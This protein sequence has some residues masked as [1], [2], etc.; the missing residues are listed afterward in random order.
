M[1]DFYV[2]PQVSRL[3]KNIMKTVFFISLFLLVR[4]PN[5]FAVTSSWDFSVTGNYSLSD[6]ASIEVANSSARLKVQNYVN[7]ANTSMLLHMDESSGNPADSSSNS[8]SATANSI[9]YSTGKL[10]NGAVFDGTLSYVSVADSSSLSVV[11]SNTIEGWVKHGSS[12]SA[13]S[14]QNPVTIADKGVYKL[15]YDNDTGKITYEL[16]PSNADNWTQA[17]GGNATTQDDVN[18]SWDLNGKLAVEASVAIG[19]DIYA[20]LGNAASDAEVWKWDG[21][22]WLQIGG[23]GFNSSWAAN[24][25]EEVYSIATDGTN[26]YAGL[27]STAGDGDVWKWNGANW[28]QIGGDGLNSGWAAATYEYVHALYWDGTYLYAGI[29]NSANDAEVWRWNGTAWTKIGGDSTNSGWTTNFESVLSLTG[30]GSTIYAGLGSSAGDAEVWRWNGSAWSRIGGDAINSSWADA[31]YEGVY[32]LYYQGSTLYAGIGNSAA[33]EGEVWRYNGTS[34]TKVGGDAANSSWADTTYEQVWAL[35]GDGTNIY[36]GI[37]NTAGDNEVWKYNGTSWSQIGGDGLNSGFSNT[38]I[39]VRSL[40]YVST[41]TLLY[42]GL[43]ATAA[44]GEMWSYNGTSWTRIAGNHINKSWGFYGLNSVE[45]LT[46]ANGKLYAGN[47]NATAGNALVWEFDGTSWGIVAG[48]GVNSSWAIN[49]YESVP[50]LMRYGGNLYAGL[51]TTANDGEVWKYASGSWS[52]IGGDSLN[53]SWGAGYEVVQSMT[54]FNGLLVAG[55][56]NSANDAE[57]WTYNGSTWTKIGGDSTNSGWT[58]NIE[59]VRSLMTYNGNLYAG[60][61]DSA[62]DADVWKWNGTA[63]SQIGG[64]TLNSSWASATF[65]TVDS[66]AVYNGYLVAG[67]GNSAGDAEVWQYNGS[68]WTRIGGDATNSSWA[69]ATYERVR[70]LSVFNG[71]LY[72]GLGSTAGDGEV[73]KWNGTAWSQVGGDSLNNGW[74]SAHEHVTS[75]AAYSG[76]MYAGLG[77]TANTD[78]MVYAYGGNS[79]LQS[80]SASQDTNW[81]HIAATYNGSTMKIYIDGTLDNSVAAS[82]TMLDTGTP[83]LI[84]NGFGSASPGIGSTP[85]KGML[86]EIRISNTDRS[87]FTTTAYV[88]SAQTV[89]PTASVM[90]TQVKNWD[91]FSTSETLNGGSIGYR[92]SIDNGTTWKYWNGSQWTTS[93]T[94]SQTN[95]A[96]VINTNIS[97]L[98]AGSGGILWQAVLTGDGTQ[99]V[100]L[101]TVQIGATADTTDPV[102]PDTVSALSALG[103]SPITSG[104][105]HSNT[106]PYFTWSG[107][108]DTGGSGIAGYYVYFDGTSDA[109]PVTNGSF[110]TTAV[111]TGSG[112]SSGKTYYLRIKAKDNAGNIADNAWDA[113]TYKYDGSNPTNPTT[114]SV[115]PAGYAATNSFTF[116]WPAGSDSGSNI[117]GYQYKTGASSGSLSDWST[118]TT[119]RSVEIPDAAYQE[120]ENTFYLRTVD[121][122]GN[123]SSTNVTANYYYAGAGPTAPQY[124]TVNQSTNTTNSFAFSWSP[125]SSFSGDESDLTYCYTVNTFPSESAC[126]YTSAGAT[127]LSAGPF[128]TQVGLNIFYVSAKN[129][130]SSGGAINYGVFGSV[131]FTANTSAPGI[132]TNVDI[133]DASLKSSS[134]WKLTVSWAVPDDTGSGVSD[135]ELYRSTDDTTYTL[136]ATTTGTAYVDTGLSQSEYYYKVRACDS[137]DNCG[138]YSTAVSMTPTGRFTSAPSLASGPAVSSVTTKKATITWSTDRKADSKI[139]YGTKSGSYFTEE[140]SNS[141]QVTDHTINMTNLQPGTTYY[142]KS[143]WTDEDGNTGASGEK[144]FTTEPSPTVKDVAAK[145]I[146]IS[147]AIIDFT[148]KGSTSVKI[149]YGETTAFGGVKTIST[150]TAESKYTVE[151]ADLKD[152]TKYY[153]K[154]NTLDSESSEYEGTILNFSTLPR[155]KITGIKIQQVVGSAQPAVLISWESN[156]PTSSVATF[157]PKGKSEEARDEVNINLQ[158]G[159]HQIL[160]RGLVPETTYIA[161]VSGRDKIGNE[162]KA[163]PKEFTTATDTRPPKISDLKI[164]GSIAKSTSDSS[165]SIAQLIVTWTTDEPSTSQVEFGEGSGSTY[166][167]KTQQDANQTLNHLVVI[168]N[169]SPSK[170]YHLRALSKDKIG[171]EGKSVDSVTITQKATDQALNLVITNLL[172]V[173]GLAGSR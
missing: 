90:T 95:S 143:K 41:G 87:S 141:S 161:I 80:T 107:A 46:E 84:G 79:I 145:T 152:G 109:D 165:N 94:T 57:V 155:P 132:P 3:C 117:A 122:A 68:S 166:S 59:T 11:Q 149:Y 48:Q 168:S 24:T 146:S 142:Y 89:Q 119:S 56:G 53:S 160:L 131:S 42:A 12:F 125:P 120:G 33:G 110:Q 129:P 127:S 83:L 92:V 58:T 103:G 9:T 77:D 169:L 15:Y 98:T 106:A 144:S 96:A 139:Q 32:A 35:T 6:S 115:S 116:S 124:V 26:A 76:K 114:V 111:Y 67:L 2:A 163:E 113:F 38:F 29:G 86:D 136:I 73:W 108:T 102:N 75:F 148:S 130:D 82:L 157:Y 40:T 37:G 128:A 66:M 153:Y 159:E 140:P 70:T 133:S 10:N 65:E 101:N 135:Y 27:G 172:E 88:N 164:E 105:W 21:S 13:N 171:N 1:R 62:G 19:T 118:T 173:F 5:A 61:G 25:A 44:S 99:Q 72:A 147:S 34:W 91:T 16:A 47:G 20:G 93:S 134:A 170:V 69:D 138:S 71:E 81:H 39:Q 55:L 64:D 158:E 63:W 7:D 137:V 4:P 49:T 31:T 78:A 50:S 151:L 14:S 100:K 60:N 18:G 23:D 36:A 8:N 28:T 126:T 51:G 74:A 97:S 121:N 54:V 85:M 52:E 156:T 17:A 167:Q 22:T 45:S 112:L 123:V 150:A 104:T 154:I 30:S 43:Q 162:A